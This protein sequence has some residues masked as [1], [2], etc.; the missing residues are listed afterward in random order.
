MEGARLVSLDAEAADGLLRA[1]RSTSDPAWRELAA[2]LWPELLGLVG[3]NAAMVSLA[4]TEDHVR[5]AALLVLEK[6]GRRD[7]RGARLYVAW[8]EANPDRDAG[9]W[10]RIVATNVARDYARERRGRASTG[11]DGRRPDKRQLEV[12][13]TLLPDGDDLPAA[14]TMSATSRHAARE[15]A[16]FASGRLPTDQ[17]RALAAWLAGASFEELGRDLGLEDAATAKRLVRA[18]VASL[19]RHATADVA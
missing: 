7:C 8:R 10:L 15:L 16:A 19:R 5:E 11:P 1:V 14:T 12:L 9:D 17:G 3:A 6:L 13:A 4:A 2:L 18:A